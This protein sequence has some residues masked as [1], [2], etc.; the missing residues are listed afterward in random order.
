[1]TNQ[2]LLI[3]LAIVVLIWSR[4]LADLYHTHFKH[5]S[6]KFL[7]FVLIMVIPVIGSALYFRIKSYIGGRTEKY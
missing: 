2:T 3:L 4:A 5:T 7:A 6:N 1:M